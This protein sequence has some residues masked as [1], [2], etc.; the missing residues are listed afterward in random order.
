[1]GSTYEIYALVAS[2]VVLALGCV[3]KGI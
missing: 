3:F 1:M 2:W